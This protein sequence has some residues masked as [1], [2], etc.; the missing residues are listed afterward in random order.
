MIQRSI[1]PSNFPPFPDRKDFELHAAMVP[2][3][4]V[5]GDLFDFF[6][7]DDDH[8]G[9]VIGDVSGKGV[10]AALF[11]SVAR[12]LLRAT[13]QHRTSP[14]ECLTYVNDSLAEQNVAA[15]FVTL[16]YGV[17]NTRTGDLE[18][19]NGGHNP[20]YV[21]S[22]DGK[23]RALR[24]KSGPLLGM[25]EGCQYKTL[26][27]R[28]APGEGLLLY[29]DGVTEAVEKGTEFFGEQ[30]LEQV[31]SEHAASRRRSWWIPCTPACSS[32]QEACPR[33]TTSRFSRC[34]T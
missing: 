34:V 16:F 13:A 15:M 9:F 25:L 33:P 20:P 3:R 4:E 29:T 30:R 14:G 27:D 12:T 10:P 24:G 17:L 23:L 6:L 18:F 5:G 1:L 32:S 28:I 21:F 8:L 19:A 26:H 2:A 22:S 7:L 31:L 11:M